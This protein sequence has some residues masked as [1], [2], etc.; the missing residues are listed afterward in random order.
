MNYNLDF[1][2]TAKKEWNKLGKVIKEQFK[3][4]LAKRLVRPHVPKDAISGGANLYK[5]KLKSAGYRLIYQVD[6][7]SI[8]ILVLAIGKRNK[9]E[10]YKTFFSRFK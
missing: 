9:M 2:P 5:I 1:V 10:V 8:V 7:T 4:K 3:K 6:D